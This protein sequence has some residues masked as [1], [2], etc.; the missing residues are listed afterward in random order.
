[1]LSQGA[2]R[3]STDEAGGMNAVHS[4]G[5]MVIIAATKIMLAQWTCY[6]FPPRTEKAR[7]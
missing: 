7:K 2:C 5:T 6:F 4:E 1:M 3:D